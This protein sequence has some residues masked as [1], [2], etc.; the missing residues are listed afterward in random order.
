MFDTPTSTL[1]TSLNNIL[2]NPK[3]YLADVCF[4]FPNAIEIWAHRGNN[5]KIT[6]E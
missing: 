2:E 3:E 6:T 5:T 4:I 1:Y